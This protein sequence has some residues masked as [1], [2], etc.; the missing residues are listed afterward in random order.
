MRLTNVSKNNAEIAA[1]V[2]LATTF[3]AKAFGLMGRKEL[4]LGEGLLFKGSKAMPC[5]SIQTTF[6]RFPLDILFLDPDMKVKSVMRHVKP[7]RVTWPVSGAVNAIEM[8]SGTLNG[9]SIE[10]GDQLHVGD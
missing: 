9:K 8:T 7:W 4:P 10:V 6:M 5:N 2:T 3:M 1:N